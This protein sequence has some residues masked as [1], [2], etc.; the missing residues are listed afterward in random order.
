[1]NYENQEIYERDYYNKGDV[2]SSTINKKQKYLVYS[3]ENITRIN[4]I[5]IKKMYKRI[6][7]TKNLE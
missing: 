5:K 2:K 1:M 7:S 6:I 4:D 3:V